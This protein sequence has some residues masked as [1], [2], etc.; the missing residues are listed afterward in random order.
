MV[1]RFALFKTGDKKFS[2]GFGVVLRKRSFES[3][4]WKMPKRVSSCGVFG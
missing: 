2:A 3:N 1:K 4:A